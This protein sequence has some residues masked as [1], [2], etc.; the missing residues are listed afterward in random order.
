M[1]ETSRPLTVRE[2]ILRQFE[3]VV[4]GLTKD[5]GDV[6]DWLDVV[7]CPLE[8]VATE[9]LK[10]RTIGIYD[11]DEQYTY[12]TDCVECDLTVQFEYLYKVQANDNV[13]VLVEAIRGN[14]FQRL[15]SP[16]VLV[17]NGTQA[18]LTI[19]IRVSRSGKDETSPRAGYAGG[20]LELRVTYRHR[21]HD[22]HR[23]RSE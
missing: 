4:R 18:R 11:P 17:E 2:R 8:E 23:L 1:D 7:R 14:L 5:D 16:Q 12:H 9:K 21:L 20:F 6:T 19:T 15:T 10:G 13:P 3:H 22:P